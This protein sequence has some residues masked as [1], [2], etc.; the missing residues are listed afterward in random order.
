MEEINKK[1]IHTELL[2]KLTTGKEMVKFL[3]WYLLKDIV[4]LTNELLKDLVGKRFFMNVLPTLDL[5]LPFL[6][7]RPLFFP[8]HWHWHFP[9]TFK[10]EEREP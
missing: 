8:L 5:L 7:E 2:K 4:I 9:I 1:Y 3:S 6:E 10:E